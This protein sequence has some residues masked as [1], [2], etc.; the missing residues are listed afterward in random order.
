MSPTSPLNFSFSDMRDEFR[1]SPKDMDAVMGENAVVECTPPK[2]HPKPVVK[3]KKD[4][5]NL[6][7]SSGK[8]I[9]IDPSGNLVI[10]N[11]QKKD[12]G[13]YQCTAENIAAIRTSKP[14][15]LKVH[16]ELYI[17]RFLYHPLYC[18]F[19]LCPIHQT[20]LCDGQLN[21]DCIVQN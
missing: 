5:D 7:L 8:R 14:M 13:R 17:I 4:G 18:L 6:N 15:R 3:W 11:V 19:W 2:G 20:Q 1:S 9:K 10:Y 21:L 12:Q 16:G